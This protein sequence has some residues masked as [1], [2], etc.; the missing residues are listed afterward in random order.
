MCTVS[1]MHM[2]T[3]ATIHMQ[4]SEDNL[5]EVVLSLHHLGLWD[6]T[7]GLAAGTFPY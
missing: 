3:H 5:Q 6:Q 1:N 7:T 2:Y 4:R